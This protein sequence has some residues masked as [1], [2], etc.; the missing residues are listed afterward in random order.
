MKRLGDYSEG[1][2]EN[3]NLKGELR[4]G[5]LT[6]QTFRHLEHKHIASGEGGGRRLWVIYILNYVNY[7]LQL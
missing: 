7:K 3:F 2:N 5:I 4:T 6:F 1:E